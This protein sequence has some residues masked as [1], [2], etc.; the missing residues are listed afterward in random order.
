MIGKINS[1]YSGFHDHSQKK[2]FD[3]SDDEVNKTIDLINSLV[4]KIADEA[5]KQRYIDPEVIILYN[6]TLRRLKRMKNAQKNK[7]GKLNEFTNR[8]SS[9]RD[10]PYS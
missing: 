2:T 3:W 7:L 6:D 10:F 4:K 1:P 5:L 8:G 9:Y